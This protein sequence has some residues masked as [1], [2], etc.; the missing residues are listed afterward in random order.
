MRFVF[1][2]IIFSRFILQPK[3]IFRNKTKTTSPK[4]QRDNDGDD[5]IGY[6]TK[7]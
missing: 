4:N 5:K 7:A 2:K 3:R 6:Q 1:K